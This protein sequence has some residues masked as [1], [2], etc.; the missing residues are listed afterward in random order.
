MDQARQYHPDAKLDVRLD[1]LT[2][3]QRAIVIAINELNEQ[4][5]QNEKQQKELQQTTEPKTH[6]VATNAQPLYTQIDFKENIS[7]DNQ[8][9]IEALMQEAGFIE[10]LT[11]ADTLTKGAILCQHHSQT[12]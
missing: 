8:R 9:R 3:E 10:L 4:L 7:E 11:S 6:F 5:T 12:I 2:N 1:N